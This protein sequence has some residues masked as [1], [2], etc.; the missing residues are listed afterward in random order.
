[1]KR[2]A[3]IIVTRCSGYACVAYVIRYPGIDGFSASLTGC[4]NLCSSLKRL[5]YLQEA[6]YAVGDCIC[7]LPEPLIMP[8]SVSRVVE[9]YLELAASIVGQLALIASSCGGG[10]VSG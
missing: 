2:E 1:M 6:R 7:G 10:G 9:A 5:G 4:N 8:E 3:R